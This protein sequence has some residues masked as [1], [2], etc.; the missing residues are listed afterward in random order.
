MARVMDIIAEFR[1]GCSCGRVHDT[2]IEDV[3]IGSGLV[4]RVGEILKKN[5]FSKKLLLIADKKTLKA[6]EGII[7]SLEGFDVEQ[8]IYEDLRIATLWE[9][10]ET[11]KLIG[12]RDI[13]LLSVGTGSLN[14]VSRLAAARQNKKLCIFATAPS[15]DGFASYG[16]PIVADGFKS[17]YPA[18]S[19]E[20]I[21]GDTE[22]LAKAPAVL[23]SAGFGDMV[24]KYV[25]LVDW[26]VSHLLTGEYYCERIAKLTRDAVDELMAM[27]DRVTAEDEETAGKIFEALLKTGI[28][29]SFTQNSRPASGSEHIVSHLIECVELRDGIIPNFHGED[30]GVCTLELLKY[31]NLLAKEE[32]IETG[33]ETVDWA[34]VYAFY[35]NMAEEVRKLNEPENIIDDVSPEK[36]KACWSEIVKVIHGVPSYEKCR[37]A[38]EIAGCKITVSDIGKSKRLFSD[39]VKYSPYMRKRLTLLRLI[40][41]IKNAPKYEIQ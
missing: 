10:R 2:T 16:A 36:L 35:G 25:G 8:K 40:G 33:K 7:S 20:V 29:M 11:E 14:D 28:G 9:V 22:I 19:P 27:A 24:A 1:R 31:Y 23:K 39:C 5:N 12:G 37:E 41:M 15:M 32:K 6:A 38:M 30:I 3:Q 18:K 26:E 21:I 17:T 34:D 13:S 4:N